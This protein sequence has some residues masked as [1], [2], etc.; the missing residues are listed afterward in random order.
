MLIFAC[1]VMPGVLCKAGVHGCVCLLLQITGYTDQ[2]SMQGSHASWK[3]L[4][5]LGFFVKFPGPGE[6]WKSFVLESPGN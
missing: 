1:N 2:K 4:K 3:V 5:S 6:S